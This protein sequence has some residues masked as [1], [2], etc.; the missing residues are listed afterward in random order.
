MGPKFGSQYQMHIK[1]TQ[2]QNIHFVSYAGFVWH[3]KITGKGNMILYTQIA[4]VQT[5]L[6][7]QVNH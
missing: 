3:G 6:F 7:M 2:M 5:R 4:M 1:I